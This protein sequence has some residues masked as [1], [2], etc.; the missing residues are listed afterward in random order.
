MAGLIRG[1]DDAAHVDI[2]PSHGIHIEINFKNF[3]IAEAGW[4]SAWEDRRKSIFFAVKAAK[5][6]GSR[7]AISKS[8]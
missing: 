3:C 8:A 1:H 7:P 6:Y 2:L 4:A 5:S